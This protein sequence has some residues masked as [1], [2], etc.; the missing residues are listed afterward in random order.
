MVLSGGIQSEFQPSR[1]MKVMVNANLN[2]RKVGQICVKLSSSEHMEIA[3]I[4]VFSILRGLLRKRATENSSSESFG[5]E[6][7][8]LEM[9]VL[10]CAFQ[11]LLFGNCGRE[12]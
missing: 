5:E 6:R 11:I 4:A 9:Q 12:G 3:L 10:W 8:K 7:E 1:G 2:N